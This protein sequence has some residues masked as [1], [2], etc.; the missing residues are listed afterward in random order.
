[1]LSDKT[2]SHN[3]CKHINI[4]TNG[5]TKEA[6]KKEQKKGIKEKGNRKKINIKNLCEDPVYTL[7]TNFSV[8]TF[9]AV[10]LLIHC[11]VSLTM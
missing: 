10:L 3:V 7:N 8:N 9:Y 5:P 1:M 4:R 2:S 11:F 6:K